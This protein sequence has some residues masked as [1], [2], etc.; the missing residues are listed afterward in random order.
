MKTLLRWCFRNITARYPGTLLVLAILLAVLSVWVASSSIYNP[1]MDNLLPENLS[2]VKEVNH[3]VEL[4][5][6]SGPLVLVL[7]GLHQSKAPPVI[8]EL[9]QR[10]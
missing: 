1:R 3:V 10:L 9:T 7:E 5:G 4:T 2:L 8:N 6:G